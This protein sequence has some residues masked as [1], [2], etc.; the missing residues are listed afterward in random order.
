MSTSTNLQKAQA[1]AL[2]HRLYKI[3]KGRNHWHALNPR[4]NNSFAPEMIT[5]PTPRPH[6]IQARVHADPILNI[7]KHPVYLM[8][9]DYLRALT[10]LTPQENE[11]LIEHWQP[12]RYTSAFTRKAGTLVPNPNLP[13]RHVPNAALKIQQ[14]ST[15]LAYGGLDIR[16]KA[17]F[18]TL[19]E[20]NEPVPF[21]T[22]QAEWFMTEIETYHTLR[23]LHLQ[24]LI[25]PE[26]G[27]DHRIARCLSFTT[28]KRDLP[29]ALWAYTDDTLLDCLS[30]SPKELA[31]R[32]LEIMKR[33]RSPKDQTVAALLVHSFS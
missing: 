2:L 33:P 25:T 13:T 24:D 30:L 31:M 11:A 14:H 5:T 8:Q 12:G 23:H 15:A 32:K 7:P 10:T 3:A 9:R 1:D 6:Y 4:A 21:K 19:L 22:L 16:H 17:M 20:H 29:Y 27:P 28:S 26:P 18:G